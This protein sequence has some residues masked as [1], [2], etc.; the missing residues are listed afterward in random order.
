MNDATSRQ[1]IAQKCLTQRTDNG[2][3]VKARLA[4]SGDIPGLL[5]VTRFQCR[6]AS[7]MRIKTLPFVISAA[8]ILTGTTCAALY[9]GYWKSVANLETV[10]NEKIWNAV[11]CRAR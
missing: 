2:T 11:S 8:V 4:P 9:L 3:S 6:A 1:T 5:Y 7:S 10:S